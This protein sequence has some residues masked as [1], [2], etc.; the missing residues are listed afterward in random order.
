METSSLA[1][2]RRTREILDK[3]GIILT[4]KYGQ[5]FLVDNN[6][7]TKIIK[8]VDPQKEDNI[9]E[10]GPGIGT[11]TLPLAC[12]CRRLVAV[13]IDG[14]LLPVLAETLAD[15][16][17]VKIIKG[18][19]KKIELEKL[20]KQEFNTGALKVAANLPY[21]VTTPFL[22][23]ILT[24]GIPLFTLTLMVQ[25]EAARRLV[26]S[27]GSADYGVLTLLTR[28][29]C[30]TRLLFKVPPQVFFPKPEVESA[31]VILEKRNEPAF[32][33][34]DAEL[35]FRLIKASFQMRRKTLKNALANFFKDDKQILDRILHQA[36]L[37]PQV[38]GEE[39]SLEEFAF[40]SKLIYNISGKTP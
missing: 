20:Y 11:L 15:N 27:P 2:P 38:R 8:A 34:P 30:H 25:K 26:A 14:R 32:S 12:R 28:Y 4:K 33:V 29:Y 18:D 31:V 9:L 17:N 35:L 10:I 13:E 5:N 1:S 21:Y 37:P 7:L 23:K 19:I 6:I 24:A 22:F 16:K 3:H 39:L 40:L 36:G